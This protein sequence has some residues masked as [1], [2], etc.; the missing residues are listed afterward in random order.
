MRATKSEM[1]A[2]TLRRREIRRTKRPRPSALRI[3]L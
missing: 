2:E 3:T 1:R